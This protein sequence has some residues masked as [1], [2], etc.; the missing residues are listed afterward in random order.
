M[1]SPTSSIFS[2]VFLQHI[3]C[4][5]IFDILVQNHNVGY[6]QYVDDI[7]IVYNRSITNIHDVFDTFNDLTPNIRFTVE[8]ETE[9]SIN[10]LDVT[11]RKDHDTFTFNVYRK[12]TAT[13]SYHP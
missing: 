11:I 5:A 8:K 4:T 3:E 9:N 2:Q 12:P 6:I 10:F 7:L 1:R 13:D